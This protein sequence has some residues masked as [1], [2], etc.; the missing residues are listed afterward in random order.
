MRS[1]PSLL[2]WLAAA[3]LLAIPARAAEDAC[4]PCHAAKENAVEKRFQ[5]DEAKWEASSHKNAGLSCDACHVGKFDDVPHQLASPWKA[6]ADCH[7]DEV[8]AL[9]ASVHGRA[10]AQGMKEAPRC[11]DCH[12]SLHSVVAGDPAAPTG[13]RKIAETCGRC[14]ANPDLVAATGVKLVQPLAAYEASV[15]ARGVARGEKAATCTACH[16]SH[17]ILPSADPKSPVNRANVPRTCGR[18]HTEIAKAFAESVHGKAATM[19]IREAPVC[20]D[21]HGEHRILGPADEASPVAASNVPKMTCE[22]CH[23][24]LRLIAKFGLKSTAVSAFESSFHGLAGRTGSQTVANCASCHGV[25]NILPSSDPKSTINPANLAKTCGAC[26]SGAGSSFAI[27]PVHV[28]PADKTEQPVVRWIRWFYLAVIPLTIGFMLVHNLGDFLRKLRRGP[29]RFSDEGTV[30]RMGKQFRVAHGLVIASFTTLV[31]TGFALKFPDS[32]WAA[33]LLRFEDHFP[34]RSWVHRG[35]GAVLIVATLYH[36]LHLALSRRDRA[37][38]RQMMPSLQDARD[39]W[40]IL[41]W[42][43]GFAKEPPTYGKFNYAEKLEYLAF[44]WGTALMAVTGLML[45]ATDFTL[46]HFPKWASDAAT[47]AHYY[48]AILASL[49]ILIWHFY[50][51]IFDP[52]VYPMETAWWNG[53]V[54]AA[55]LRHSRPRY[56]A[57]LQRERAAELDAAED[58]EP[59]R[60]KPAASDGG[61]ASAEGSEPPSPPA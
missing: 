38:L 26:H 58:R 47:A 10:A 5:I 6:C 29:L 3:A 35:A 13:P 28:T 51:V 27:G 15:H 54:S 36:C 8:A 50:M 12:G 4:L 18:C 44:M 57:A 34:L 9:A 41:R 22:R 40:Q 2:G 16:G 23:G 42:Q 20:T 43:Y 49:S 1:I 24:D 59:P 53:R 14:H 55:H 19:G 56:Y 45:W 7:G 33:P 48:E 37:M 52:D 30:V 25:H 11:N 39:L 60:P 31:V 61:E 21:C 46:R 32:W 17:G